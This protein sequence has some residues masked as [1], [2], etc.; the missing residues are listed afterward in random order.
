MGQRTRREQ[1][2]G[3]PAACHTVMPPP[4]P[5]PYRSGERVRGPSTWRP[6]GSC[7]AGGEVDGPLT[8]N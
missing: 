7:A 5:E 2:E 3:A 8:E 4:C 6:D 1:A